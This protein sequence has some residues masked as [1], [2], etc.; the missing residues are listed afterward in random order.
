MV[1]RL[2][3]TSTSVAKDVRAR[4]GHAQAIGSLQRANLC[5]RAVLRGFGP[6]VGR[7]TVTLASVARDVRARLG[8]A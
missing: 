7:L 3:M 5:L 1:G 6:L 4:L 2:T 8:H